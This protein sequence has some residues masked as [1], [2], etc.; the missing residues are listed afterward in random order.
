MLRAYLLL[1]LLSL[2]SVRGGEATDFFIPCSDPCN[3][4]DVN[5]NVVASVRTMR[6]MLDYTYRGR[7]YSSK[8]SDSFMGPTMCV[9]PGQTLWIKLTNNMTDE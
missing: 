2:E 9:W 3:G 4:G 5:Y 6:K 1:C 8:G 7:T